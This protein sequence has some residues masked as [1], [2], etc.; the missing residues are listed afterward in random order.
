MKVSR[1]QQH[2]TADPS[3]QVPRPQSTA[4]F[5]RQTLPMGSFIKVPAFHDE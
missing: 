5:E 1:R 4:A 2:M 3:G